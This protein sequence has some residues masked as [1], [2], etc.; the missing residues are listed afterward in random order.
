MSHHFDTKLAREDPSLNLCDF[1]LFDGPSGKTVMAMTVNPDVGLSAPDTLHPEGLYAFRFDLNGDAREEVTFKFR[2]GEPR[3]ADGSEHTHIQPFVVRRAAGNDALRGDAGETLIEGETGSVAANSGVRAYVGMAPDLFAANAGFRAFMTAFYK[4]RRFDEGSLLHQQNPFARRNVT[5][6]VLEAPSELIGKG[7]I[8]AWA[9]I[10]L[11]GHAPEVQ[12]SRWGLPMVTHLFLSD[13]GDLELKEQFNSSVP[14]EDLERFAKWIAD[15]A[16]KMTTY[17]GSAPNSAAYGK[18]IAGRL[19]PNTL[20]Y[21]LGTS[22]A[23]ARAS[24]NG[25]PLG[26]DV[27]DVML[28]LAANTP[29]VDGLAPDRGRIRKDFPYYGAPYTAEE[30]VGVTPMPRPAK[31]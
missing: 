11:F 10:S 3:H 2:F 16:E 23:F 1:Y 6:I 25:R 21:E 7:K 4:D 5:A 18:Q 12:V 26:D 29:I 20:P 17:A 9:T 19:C 15:F 14:A 8:Y 22:A 24:F 27:L 30:Q 28:T 31:R 13:P